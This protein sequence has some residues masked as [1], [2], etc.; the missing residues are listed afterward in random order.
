MV[1]SLAH[2]LPT[3]AAGAESPAAGFIN[4]ESILTGHAIT[5]R[6]AELDSRETWHAVNQNIESMFAAAETF[7][8]MT[9]V[10]AACSV[11]E[12][13]ISRQPPSS[14]AST[15]TRCVGIAQ[16]SFSKVSSTR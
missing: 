2:V 14:P 8:Q 7:V 15:C 12:V 10:Y 9:A 13:A 16:R 3:C 1:M 6:A 4:L 11:L 5:R